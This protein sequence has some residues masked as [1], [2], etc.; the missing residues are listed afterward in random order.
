M[1]GFAVLGATGSAVTPAPST[2]LAQVVHTFLQ[3]VEDVKQAYEKA[4]SDPPTPLSGRNF[5][6]TPK[7]LNDYPE[8]QYASGRLLDTSSRLLCLIK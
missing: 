4:V 8:N 7:S 1:A 6:E 3:Q 5:S 2:Q